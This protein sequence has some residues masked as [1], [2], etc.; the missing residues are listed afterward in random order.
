MDTTRK[1]YNSSAWVNTTT[2]RWDGSSWVTLS[3]GSGGSDTVTKMQV[4]FVAGTE[5][6]S[7]TLYIYDEDLHLVATSVSGTAADGV[8]TV[9]LVTPYEL[10]SGSS[11]TGAI[12]SGGYGADLGGSTIS[13]VSRYKDTSIS[14]PLDGGWEASSWSLDIAFLDASDN[15]LWGQVNGSL[16]LSNIEYTTKIYYNDPVAY[17]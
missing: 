13:G 14:D 1:Y 9:N 2:K 6:V 10:T 5:D 17:P 16:S 12:V 4:R 8:V 11:Y 7:F 15:I 3:G